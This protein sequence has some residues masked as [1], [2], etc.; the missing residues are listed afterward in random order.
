M[1]KI[2]RLMSLAAVSL[3]CMYGCGNGDTIIAVQGYDESS[4]TLDSKP[5]DASPRPTVAMGRIA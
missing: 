2:N 3:C 4:L 1:N 5:G